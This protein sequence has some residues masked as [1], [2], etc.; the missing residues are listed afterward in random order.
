MEHDLI[1]V[2]QLPI[3]TERLR[4]VSDQ[5]AAKIA[6]ARSLAVTD[7]TVK[8]VKAMRADLNRDFAALEE[9][10]K[11]IKSDV[12]SP[13]EAFEAVYKQYVSDQYRQADIDLKAEIDRVE[14]VRKEEKTA[15]VKAYFDEYA[16][17]RRIDFIAWERAGIKVGLSDSMKSLKGSA[18]AFIDRVCDDLELIE[19]QACNEE[20]LVEYKRSLNASQAITSVAARHRAIEDQKA[21]RAELEARKQAEAEAVKRVEAAIPAPLAPPVVKPVEEADPMRTLMFT[22]TAPLSKLKEL[23]KYLDDGGYRYE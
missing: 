9:R 12:L 22:V 19:T 5:I 18:K 16:E 23:K 17:S 15:E 8:I 20:I 13:Y 21:R 6:E 10:R 2:E 4:T 11:A 14:G 3:I 7:E 1:V